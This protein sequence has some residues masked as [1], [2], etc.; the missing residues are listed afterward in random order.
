MEPK[1]MAAVLTEQMSRLEPGTR[2]HN[3]RQQIFVADMELAERRRLVL[4]HPD[5]AARLCE[6]PLGYTKPAQWSGFIPPE[7]FNGEHNRSPRR[8]ALIDI[9]AEALRR[10][11]EGATP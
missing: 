11:Q 10:E 3:V 4:S 8:D 9:A 5:L 2:E 6:P 1:S 7:E